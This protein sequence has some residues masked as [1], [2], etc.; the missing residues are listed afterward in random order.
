MPS[1]ANSIVSNETVTGV[2]LISNLYFIAI[3]YFNT[4]GRSRRDDDPVLIF[5]PPAGL[6]RSAYLVRLLTSHL[7]INRELGE[8]QST[9][10][11]AHALFRK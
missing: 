10:L 7:T 9:I 1:K 8:S 4:Q 3:G 2:S 6:G 11:K 5:G